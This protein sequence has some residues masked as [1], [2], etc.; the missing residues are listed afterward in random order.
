M[1]QFCTIQMQR[2]TFDV[3]GV[4]AHVQSAL[5]RLRELAIVSHRYKKVSGAEQATLST[6][7]QSD[8]YKNFRASTSPFLST[9][10]VGDQL[11]LNGTPE[12]LNLQEEFVG[13]AKGAR[14]ALKVCS[15]FCL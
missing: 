7:L 14:V 8:D 10:L 1:S 6:L 11:F 12:E 13:S 9:V 3:F 2:F 15:L 5:D 4:P